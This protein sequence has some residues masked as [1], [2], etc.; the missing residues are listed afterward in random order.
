MGI[1]YLNYTA[2]S[3]RRAGAMAEE[4]EQRSY[5]DVTKYGLVHHVC[6]TAP[7]DS[8]EG[9]RA[10]IGQLASKRNVSLDVGMTIFT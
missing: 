7:T 9:P 5:G 6:P 1:V 10:V 3:P 4:K 8:H 2:W